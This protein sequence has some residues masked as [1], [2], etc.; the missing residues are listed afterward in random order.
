MAR[1]RSR[2]SERACNQ[3]PPSVF[4]I[5][6]VSGIRVGP[7]QGRSESQETSHQFVEALTVFS[8]P[9]ARIFADEA[10][11]AGESREILVGHSRR[12]RLLLVCFTESAE[13]V[14]RIFSARRATRTEKSDYEEN[15]TN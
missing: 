1:V 7:A 2:W 13:G 8:D 9:L 14:V 10:H 12:G 15:L 11:S 5:Y 6:D 4:W 3:P